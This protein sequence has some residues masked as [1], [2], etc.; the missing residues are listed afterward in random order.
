MDVIWFHP[1]PMSIIIVCHVNCLVQ[2][3]AGFKQHFTLD[4]SGNKTQCDWTLSTY[5]LCSLLGGWGTTT[6]SVLHG[7]WTNTLQSTELQVSCMEKQQERIQ[8]HFKRG[9]L[10]FIIHVPHFKHGVMVFDVCIIY[11]VSVL[12]DKHVPITGLQPCRWGNIGALKKDVAVNLHFNLNLVWLQ[13]GSK[14]TNVSTCVD[15]IMCFDSGDVECPLQYKVP[16][17]RT[18]CPDTTHSATVRPCFVPSHMTDS[19]WDRNCRDRTRTCLSY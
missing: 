8:H 11:S 7:N 1:L 12:R 9:D 6:G 13:V 16:W 17:R 2:Q 4:K 15:L 5:V 3:S 10:T 14:R 18:W 19:R